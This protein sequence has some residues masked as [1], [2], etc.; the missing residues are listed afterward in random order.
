MNLQPFIINKKD[1]TFVHEDSTLK[2]AL[3]ILRS[4]GFRCVPILDK[5]GTLFRGTIYR[6]HIYQHIIDKGSLDLPVTHLLKNV[7]KYIFTNSSFYQI[8]FAVR[9][10]PYITILNE[11][12]TFHGIMTHRSFE[13]ALYGAWEL[14]QP[15]LI[16]TI[17]LPHNQQG[18]LAKLIKVISRY[19]SI[20]SIISWA[21][22]ASEDNYVTIGVDENTTQETLYKM[23][24]RLQRYDIEIVMTNHTRDIFL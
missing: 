9:D 15:H 16:L 1:I 20:K 23:N 24:N 12:H 17:K 13:K 4:K 6:Q 14:D 11:D 8:M 19:S 3:H 2:D 18:V 7:T 10:L 5:S 21:D 22:R